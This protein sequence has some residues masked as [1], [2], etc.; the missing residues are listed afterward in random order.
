[1]LPSA[2][3]ASQ[4]SGDSVHYGIRLFGLVEGAAIFASVCAA[5]GEQGVP[6]SHGA[7][8]LRWVR[9]D[10]TEAVLRAT[11]GSSPSCQARLPFFGVFHASPCCSLPKPPPPAVRVDRR[12]GGDP[13]PP[14]SSTSCAR[15]HRKLPRCGHHRPLLGVLAPA[16]GYLLSVAPEV[17]VRSEG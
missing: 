2:L 1:M 13:R 3:S 6:S 14:R 10:R 4:L 11:L 5:R 12:C 16:G 7:V 8:A 15:E 9:S 17:R